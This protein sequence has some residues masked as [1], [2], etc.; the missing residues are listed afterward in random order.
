MK[1]F[2]YETSIEG[3]NVSTLMPPEIAAQ[4]D[5]YLEYA[6]ERPATIPSPIIS[7][8]R[9]MQGLRANQTQF[10]ISLFVDE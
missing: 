9:R 3:K 10:P 8:L 5:G 1:V 2:G 4:H 7:K 6:K